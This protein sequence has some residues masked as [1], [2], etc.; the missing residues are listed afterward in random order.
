MEDPD[1]F[2]QKNRV[3]ADKHG[4]AWP[5]TEICRDCSP[6]C[7][8]FCAIQAKQAPWTMPVPSRSTLVAKRQAGVGSVVDLVALIVDVQRAED[9]EAGVGFEVFGGKGQSGDP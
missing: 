3:L 6:I 9:K 5:L 8:Y 2:C 1:A 7:V 4:D